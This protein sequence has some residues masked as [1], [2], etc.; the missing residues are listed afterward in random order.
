MLSGKLN[1]ILFAS[2]FIFITNYSN[3]QVLELWEIQGDGI[4]SPYEGQTV[5]T[6]ANVVT[7]KGSGFFFIQS[8]SSNTD[9]DPSTS[10]AILVDA[11]FFGQIGDL[12]NVSGRVEEEDGNTTIGG[13]NIDIDVVGNNIPLPS[14][15]VFDENYPS[16]EVSELH[17]LERSENMLVNFN[18]TAIAPSNGIEQA[19]LSTSAERPFRE[20]G[21]LHPGQNGLPVWDG[22]PEIFWFDPN[23]LNQP[24]NR[25][26]NAGDQIEA[27][28]IVIEADEGQWLALPTSY[29]YT[30]I[31][32]PQAV[33][34]PESN[35]FVIGSLNLLLL[36]SSDD[37]IETKRKKLALYITEQMQLPD[38]IAV[39][40]AGSLG[41][42]QNLAYN[43]N[44]LV[45]DIQ[46]EAYLEYGSGNIHQG[47]LVKTGIQD[48]TITQLG[49]N[50]PFS[51]GG[52]LHDRPPLLLQASLPT[53]PPTLIQVLNIHSRSLIGIEGSNSNFVRNKRHQQ[54]ISIANMIQDLRTAG[55]LVVLGDMNAYHFTDG[56]V[57]V[58]SQMSG[59]PSLGAS[60]SP[61]NIVNPPLEMPIFDLPE[62]ERYSY[63][64]QG[65]AQTLD[66]CMIGELDGLQSN[67]MSYARGNADFALDYDANP[68][69]ATRS[70]DHDGLVVYLEALNPIL[71]AE[72]LLLS[73]N[74]ISISHAQPCQA[75]DWIHISSKREALQSLQLYNMQGKLI[76]EQV[77][78]GNK[79][80]DFQLPEVI[81][82]NST[83]I[84][85]VQG[86]QQI[87]NQLL[88]VF[89]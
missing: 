38:I 30:A 56:Y 49:A 85:T 2:L 72:E 68:N 71:D 23:G 75:G 43:I 83:Y 22:N 40:E 7:A 16:G 89:P 47:F 59:L 17:S 3:G 41:A 51:F 35:E 84:L 63:V 87:R 12:V 27:T 52:L 18:A 48:V 67:G 69:V 44:L 34:P 19:A 58:V 5:E 14:P 55:N 11:S 45:P 32:D 10:D 39:Q 57:D 65:N 73:Q 29:S 78:K 4:A 31:N 80:V 15:I 8:T 53:N 77:L 42:L 74:D 25:F 86:K 64:F 20:P 13:S 54:A 60:I 79:K 62:E 76:Y 36:F 9:N 66:H 88:M 26:I 46:Y 28:A 50:E 61:I 1:K 21:I 81:G 82:T 70:S 37:D 24:N 33:R 6:E